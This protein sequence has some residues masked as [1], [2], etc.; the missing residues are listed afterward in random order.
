MKPGDIDG[1]LESF[2]KDFKKDT[3]SNEVKDVLLSYSPL[4]WENWLNDI[5]NHGIGYPISSISPIGDV[6]V[7]MPDYLRAN[8]ISTSNYELAIGNFISKVFYENPED[9][10]L[11]ER[12]LNTYIAL[13]GYSSNEI[14]LKILRLP[15]YTYK[16][17]EHNF[18]KTLV[19]L[20]LSKS[21]KLVSEEKDEIYDYLVLHGINEMIHEP[22][23]Y[24]TALRFCYLQIS[25]KK[26][27]EF[28]TILLSK[29]DK[30][31][32]D[33]LKEIIVPLLRDKIEEIYSEKL[34]SFYSDLFDW[35]LCIASPDSNIGIESNKMTKHLVLSIAETVKS[36]EI[37]E[38]ELTKQDMTI[39]T[40]KPIYSVLF[41][42]SILIHEDISPTKIFDEPEIIIFV[43]NNI[44]ANNSHNEKLLFD[45]FKHN[46]NFVLSTKMRFL[47]SLTKIYP[48]NIDLD[49][50]QVLLYSKRM[51]Y[52][53]SKKSIKYE[54]NLQ[55]T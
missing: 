29:F 40:Y 52:S 2:L 51:N 25:L 17:G 53:N 28:L 54:L 38:L 50:Y 55:N 31:K 12:L 48:L 45:L 19:L 35:L 9:I 5:I 39:G 6:I 16:K 7:D 1:I 41:L 24:S 22:Y 27:F 26:F 10:L 8:Q 15:T 43:I 34:Q 30:S 13:S 23:F 47:D 37:D 21:S 14:L 42:L 32:D 46:L 44:V 4:E 20:A 11:L 18:L 33:K 3:Q 36:G 49:T